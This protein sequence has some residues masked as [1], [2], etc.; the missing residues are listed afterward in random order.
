MN[1]EAAEKGACP[2]CRRKL[3]WDAMVQQMRGQNQQRTAQDRPTVKELSK[4]VSGLANA[5]GR[6]TS[7]SLRHHPFQSTSANKKAARGAERPRWTKSV[8]PQVT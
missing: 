1:P 8:E 2:L 4:N 7:R 3:E 5:A 6:Q